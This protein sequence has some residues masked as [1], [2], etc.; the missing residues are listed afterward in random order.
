[1]FRRTPPIVGRS[2]RVRVSGKYFRSYCRW[3][4]AVSVAEKTLAKTNAASG[5]RP[6][7][8]IAPANKADSAKRKRR[9]VFIDMP[10]FELTIHPICP[11]SS[12][13]RRYEYEN[14]GDVT[15]SS[16]D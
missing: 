9:S 13:K 8:S 11:E 4:Q 7:V 2:R 5:L 1:M 10:W 16:Q 15:P 6:V 12:G 3:V 14:S